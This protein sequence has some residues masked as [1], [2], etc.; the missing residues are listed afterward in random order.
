MILLFLSD[1]HSFIHEDGGR[2]GARAE[3]AGISCAAC[4]P[5]RK[6][7]AICHGGGKREEEEEDGAQKERG[8]NTPEE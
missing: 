5:R 8:E 2:A 6:K 1:M 3:E 7:R 4:S